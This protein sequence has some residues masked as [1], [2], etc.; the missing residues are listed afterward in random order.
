[1]D[2]GVFHGG[3]HTFETVLEL[4]KIVH[5][6]AMTGGD[7]DGGLS[8]NGIFTVGSDRPLFEHSTAEDMLDCGVV[9]GERKAHVND[10]GRV[11]TWRWKT[12][13]CD[14]RDALLR[15]RC[16]RRGLR[17]SRP[18]RGGE[19]A[20]HVVCERAA[21]LALRHGKHLVEIAVM[22]MRPEY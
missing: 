11:G 17:P 2:V 20:V 22:Q 21:F 6:H 10:C 3:N 15:V 14:G 13:G 8:V 9:A 19:L 7:F 4:A 16:G 5:G 1:M 12:V 18:C